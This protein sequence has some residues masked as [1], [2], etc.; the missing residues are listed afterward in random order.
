[1]ESI[2]KNRLVWE[3]T[4]GVGI[5]P[6]IVSTLVTAIVFSF[7]AIFGLFHLDKVFW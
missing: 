5:G 6:P 4:E 7:K 2:R 3:S 1:M